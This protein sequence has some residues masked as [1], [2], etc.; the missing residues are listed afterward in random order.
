MSDD[1][2]S[3]LNKFHKRW[4]T[5]DTIVMDTVREVTRAPIVSRTRIEHG[6][7][8]EVYDLAFDGAPSLIVRITRDAVKDMEPERWVLGQCEARG[9][10]VPHI[11]LIKHLTLDGAPLHI[12]IMEKL[13]G[14]RLCDTPLAPDDLRHVLNALGAWLARFHSI[15]IDGYG[16]LNGR[17]EAEAKTYDG[18]AD[19]LLTL[20]PE[21]EATAQHA[22]IALAELQRWLAFIDATLRVARPRSVL[23]HNDLYARHVLVKDGRLS[24]VI[25]FGE[26]SG[27]PAL[28]EFAKWDFYEGETYPVQWFKDGYADQALFAPANAPLY[29]A[30]RL[31]N[32]LYLLRF[33][34]QSGYA[35]G[36]A[37]VRQKLER[38]AQLSA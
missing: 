12:C 20:V 15:P 1:L 8:N 17:G 25:D 5:P 31:L 27:E 14:T 4:N 36:I 13:E 16:Y 11:H 29:N 32:G 30:L 24:G 26:V 18:T 23:A 2:T 22:G 19:W 10:P 3:H 6:F 9:I 21:F 28:N 7:A 34:H 33:Y 35:R 38:F 37:E